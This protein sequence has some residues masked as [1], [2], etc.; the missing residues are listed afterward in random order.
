MPTI[1]EGMRIYLADKLTDFK[2]LLHRKVNN[3]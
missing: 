2:E 1:K 3:E